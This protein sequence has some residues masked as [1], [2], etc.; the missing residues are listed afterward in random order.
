ME[1]LG[2]IQ[3]GLEATIGDEIES[4]SHSHNQFQ[5]GRTFECDPEDRSDRPRQYA[6]LTDYLNRFHRAFGADA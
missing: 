4:E 5:M 3:P 6:L 2:S 1:R